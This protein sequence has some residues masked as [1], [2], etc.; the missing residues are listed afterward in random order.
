VIAPPDSQAQTQRPPASSSIKAYSI[1]FKVPGSQVDRQ[2]LHY[3]CCQAAENLSSFSDPVLWTNLILQRSHD[4][5]VIRNALVALSSLHKDHLCGEFS[6]PGPGRVPPLKSM[7]LVSKCHRQLR[8]YLSSPDALPEVAL[9][10]SVIFYTFESLIGDTQRAI[11]HL[12]QGLV[13]LQRCQTDHPHLFASSDEIFSHLTALLSRLDI[14]A[15]TFDDRRPPA[16]TLVSSLET[17]GVVSVV[18]DA[19]FNADHGESVLVKLQNWTMHHIIT[20][21]EHKHK[22]LEEFPS[23]ILYERLVLE[24]QFERYRVAIENLAANAASGGHD[25]SRQRQQHIQRILLLRIHSQIF[26]SILVENIPIRSTTTI[27][28]N[29]TTIPVNST[30]TILV[31]STTTIPIHSATTSTVNASVPAT[32]TSSP[33]TLQGSLQPEHGLHAALFNISALLSSLGPAPSYRDGNHHPDLPD[34]TSKEMPPPEP[35]QPGNRVFTLSTHLIAAL[36]I[37]C[38]KTIDR[39]ALRT[40]LSLLQ[41]SQLPAR[42]GL[43][44]AATAASI[45][46]GLITRARKEQDEEEQD[47]NKS[48]VVEKVR[49]GIN[50]EMGAEEEEGDFDFD[51]DSQSV[52]IPEAMPVP[53]STA[54]DQCYRSPSSDY[55]HRQLKLEDVG[56]GIVDADGGLDEVLKV[57]HQTL[58]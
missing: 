39:Q 3:Y 34:T 57:L 58:N 45:V 49:E 53:P 27:P 42:D 51:F 20:H 37:V 31:R 4:Q 40:A 26:H 1:P 14:Q 52:P 7:H 10:C 38:L 43:W 41:H 54:T 19:F 8:T 15:S 29:S 2:L 24:A 5:P 13:L 50:T 12:D 11:W 17:S 55:K 32:P 46:Q 47:N 16:L 6:G 36:Y 33:S 28:V 23:D 18:P 48:K 21:V 35:T 30:T 44:D 56:S 9:I 25:S 22:N